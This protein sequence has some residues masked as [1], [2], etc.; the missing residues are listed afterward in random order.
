MLSRK[1]VL[2]TIVKQGGSCTTPFDIDCNTDECPLIFVTQCVAEFVPVE[3]ELSTKYNKALELLMN[4]Y[5][6]EDLIEDLL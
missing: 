1:D 5:S 4:E 6:E 2:L 3:V